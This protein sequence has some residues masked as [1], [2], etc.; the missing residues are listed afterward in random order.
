MRR[1][2]LAVTLVFSVATMVSPHAALA[3]PATIYFDDS[4]PDIMRLGNSLH[5]EIGLRKSNGAIAYIVD[6]TTGQ[7]VTLGSRYECLWGA[8]FPS[9]TP[10]YVGVLHARSDGLSASHGPSG[11][12]GLRRFLVRHD[13]V[14]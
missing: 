10:T 14:P 6:K 13:A 1:F 11:A 2:V 5:Y 7:Q 12:G 4:A 3:A 8:V 9:G